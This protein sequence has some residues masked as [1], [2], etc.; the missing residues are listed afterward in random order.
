V[1]ISNFLQEMD[2]LAEEKYLQKSV[3]SLNFSLTFLEDLPQEFFQFLA[4]SS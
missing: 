3:S 2:R 1:V 4:Q